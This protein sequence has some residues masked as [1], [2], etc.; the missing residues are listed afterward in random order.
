MSRITIAPDA[1]GS[2]VFT[3]ASPATNTSRVV[4]LPDA[5][6]TLVG[7]DA[8]QTLTNK[9]LTAPVITGGSLSG[10]SGAL[11]LG[12]AQA[13]TSGTAIDFT[14]I[15][16]WVKRVTVV[17]G[18]VS[19]NGASPVQIQI[20]DSGGIET[21]GYSSVAFSYNSGTAA[22][23]ST[24]YLVDEGLTGAAQSR[25]GNYVLNLLQGSTWAGSGILSVGAC[26][27][28]AGGKS[29]S[30]TLDRIRITTVN[31]TDTFDAGI[32]NIMYEG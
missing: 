19:T 30:N 12:T 20:G 23:S 32:I 27:P 26:T 5:T 21:T 25:N 6:T 29:L 7:T 10:T 2:A 11:T 1:S 15:P 13:T 22:S 28:S 4:T 9:T 8:T 16:S 31:A 24:G 17:F 14:G 18:G 3:V